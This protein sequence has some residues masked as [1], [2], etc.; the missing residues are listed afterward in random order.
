MHRIYKVQHVFVTHLRQQWVRSHSCS[1]RAGCHT[2]G[3][4]VIVAEC[5]AGLDR[6]DRDRLPGAAGLCDKTDVARTEQSFLGII[7]L[8]I[9]T[10]V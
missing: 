6:A 10:K 9:I 8:D 5:L 1:L 4:E 2:R 7:A 3:Q